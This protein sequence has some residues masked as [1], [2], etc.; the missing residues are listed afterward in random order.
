V[1]RVYTASPDGDLVVSTLER[2]FDT[3]HGG[4]TFTAYETIGFA[5]G[6]VRYTYVSLG[7]L[8]AIRAHAVILR[9]LRRLHGGA[10]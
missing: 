8:E 4:G 2:E 9:R 6:D 10:A 5:G 3:I 7:D 1:T